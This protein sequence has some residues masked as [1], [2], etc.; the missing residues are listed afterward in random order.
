MGGFCRYW[1]SWKNLAI[2]P[3]THNLQRATLDKNT[4]QNP[5]QQIIYTTLPIK[6]LN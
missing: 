3:N 1:H 6:H 2:P 4:F 5:T